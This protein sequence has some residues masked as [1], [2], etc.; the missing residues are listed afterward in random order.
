MSSQ[1]ARPNN[2][3]RYHSKD[4]RF[5]R[6][7]KNSTQKLSPA[8]EVQKYQ[9]LFD[10]Y[11]N[12]RRKYFEKFSI[13]G[14]KQEVDL[15]RKYNDHRNNLIKFESTLSDE[16]KVTLGISE[17]TADKD[18]EFDE[19]IKIS[20]P[21]QLKSQRET[22]FSNDKEESSGSMEDYLKYKKP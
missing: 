2:K 22:D 8:K 17:S 9:N 3:K 21:H 4:K 15:E 12:A 14:I 20:S 7:N 10:Q 18:I 19:N 11:L 16:A 1:K 6:K 13:V 5:Y